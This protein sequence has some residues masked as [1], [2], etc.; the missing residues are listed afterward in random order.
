[1]RIEKQSY[2]KRS[3]TKKVFYFII[4]NL[5]VIST[6]ISIFVI[7]RL[8]LEQEEGIE[9]ARQKYEAKEISFKEKEKLEEIQFLKTGPGLGLLM[10]SIIGFIFFGLLCMNQSSW[11]YDKKVDK[12]KIIRNDR[13]IKAKEFLKS[14]NVNV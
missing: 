3:F 1:M 6:I 9:I 14:L 13:E 10:L 4:A 7:N 8:A 5:F 11:T 2:Y 12:I